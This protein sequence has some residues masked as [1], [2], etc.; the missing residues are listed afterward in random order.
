MLPLLKRVVIPASVLFLGADLF[1]ASS[2]LLHGR[3]VGSAIDIGAG[4]IDFEVLRRAARK[5]GYL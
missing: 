2:A 4:L 5:Q 1:F 3:I